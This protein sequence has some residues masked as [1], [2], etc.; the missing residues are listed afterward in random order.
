MSDDESMYTRIKRRHAEK[1]VDNKWKK[2]GLEG[3]RAELE[4]AAEKVQRRPLA[5]AEMEEFVK[6]IS[7]DL[8]LIGRCE[9]CG[10]IE[11]HYQRFDHTSDRSID[12]MAKDW[13]G[14]F[15]GGNL[16][17][18][19]RFFTPCPHGPHFGSK[20]TNWMWLNEHD[21]AWKA[22][23]DYFARKELDNDLRRG[24]WDIID[25]A[26]DRW[27]NRVLMSTHGWTAVLEKLKEEKAC[28]LTEW[29]FKRN[30]E[31]NNKVVTE[32]AECDGRL[33]SVQIDLSED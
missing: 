28:P 24:S 15:R 1:E 2:W 32:Y 27:K 22:T 12:G 19:Q 16:M 8:L 7:N 18:D 14:E 4:Y 13:L 30:V 21:K 33:V 10:G 9:L 11:I 6:S 26:A 3:Q 31:F 25:V 17:C 29:I 20:W 23:V 5:I